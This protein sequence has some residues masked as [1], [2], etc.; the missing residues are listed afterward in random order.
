MTARASVRRRFEDA[1]EPRQHDVT[2]FFFDLKLLLPE[3]MTAGDVHR[4]RQ[5]VER[6]LLRTVR[7]KDRITWTADGF[8]LLVATTDSA[9]AGAAAERV[10]QDVCAVLG[11]GDTM[12][13]VV[14]EVDPDVADPTY[15]LIPGIDELHASRIGWLS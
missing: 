14:R 1:I 15:T 8:F 7:K 6:R 13:T 12:E 3:G 9:R 4:A 10:H 2:S 11:T 5:A